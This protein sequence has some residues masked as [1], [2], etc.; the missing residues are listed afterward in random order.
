[1]QHDPARIEDQFAYPFNIGG[2]I[3][4]LRPGEPVVFEKML[5]WKPDKVPDLTDHTPACRGV[6]HRGDPPDLIQPKPNQS[7]P[8]VGRT[9][10]CACGTFQRSANAASPQWLPRSCRNKTRTLKTTGIAGCCARGAIG[11]AAAALTGV[12]TV[13]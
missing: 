13:K 5:I 9:K 6:W 7:G 12:L 10:G 2:F 8:L 11:H 4:R 3:D 1:V